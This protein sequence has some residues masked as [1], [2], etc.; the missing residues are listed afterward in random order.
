MPDVR[1]EKRNGIRGK[2]QKQWKTMVRLRFQLSFCDFTSHIPAPINRFTQNQLN[3][4]RGGCCGVLPC[5]FHIHIFSFA[6]S[7]N[8][9]VW[10]HLRASK[11]KCRI[12]FSFLRCAIELESFIDRMVTDAMLN[13]YNLEEV[14][15]LCFS[16]GCGGFL[17]EHYIYIS[18]LSNYSYAQSRNHN[19]LHF[20]FNG[21]C[22]NNTNQSR[23]PNVLSENF[24]ID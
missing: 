19:K 21:I 15:S 16:T 23:L 14:E 1:V 2:T 11:R 24:S 10:I 20:N 17:K 7:S 4:K 18:K 13:C 6:H 9:S 12:S 3:F 8:C 22:L 5:Q